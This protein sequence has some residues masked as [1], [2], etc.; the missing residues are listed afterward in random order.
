[1]PIGLLFTIFGAILTMYGLFSGE[2]IYAQ[3]SLGININFWW[4]LL[5]LVFGLAFLVSARKRGAEKEGEKKELIS[6]LH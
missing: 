3:H 6:K 5:M 2:E 4:G 1:M